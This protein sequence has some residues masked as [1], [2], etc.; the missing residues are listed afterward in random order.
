MQRDARGLALSTDSA[1]A[2]A[3]FDRAV[4]HYLKFHLDTMALVDQ[5]LAVDPGFVMGHCIKSYLLLIGA[6]SAHRP[7][8]ATHLA[9]ARAG[10]AV[11][12]K[13]EQRHVAAL[14]AWQ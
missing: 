10:A 1:E 9:A 8:I 5:V 14:S 2:A 3:L 6:N 12:T 11:T 7:A 13:R 4:E